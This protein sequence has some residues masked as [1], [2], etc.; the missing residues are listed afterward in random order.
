MSFF[1]RF[2]PGRVPAADEEEDLPIGE[3]EGQW[4]AESVELVER[5]AGM[6]ELV[7]GDMGGL[8]CALAAAGEAE[9]AEEC[10]SGSSV[11]SNGGSLPCERWV[12]LCE[13]AGPV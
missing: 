10:G 8:A 4:A 1:S 2:F 6:V 13:A 5:P 3:A 11:P 9:A 7:L 12:W